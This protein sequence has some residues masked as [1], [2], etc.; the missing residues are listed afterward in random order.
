MN[1]DEIGK[2]EIIE[3][4]WGLDERRNNKAD[5]REN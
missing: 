1:E 2:I 3:L 5:Q 4:R